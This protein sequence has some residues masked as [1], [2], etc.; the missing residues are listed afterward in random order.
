MNRLNSCTPL[1]TGSSDLISNV[2]FDGSSYFC[3]VEYK[4]EIIKLDNC[5]NVQHKYCTCREYERICYDW[6]EC[7]FWASSRTCSSKIFKLDRNMNEIDHISIGCGCG[8]ITGISYN[9][10]KDTLM[11]SSICIVAEIDKKC[12]TNSILYS[13]KCGW[14]VDVLSLSPGTLLTVL[15][16]GTYYIEV[17]DACGK[18]QKCY[19]ISNEH[20][21][22][23]L[24]FN[25]C[26][27]KSRCA[28]IEVYCIKKN[29]YPNICKLKLSFTELGFFPH[30][31]NY[32]LCDDCCCAE[33]SCRQQDACADIMESIALV[34]AALSHI[35][36]AEGEKLQKVLT[37]TNDVEEILR[38]NRE[39]NK[40]IVNTT[41]LEHVLHAKL[42]A[43]TDCNLCGE[44]CHE[45]CSC[46]K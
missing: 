23:N 7:C 10:R 13:G 37:E 46:E 1:I 26:A 41:H 34:E 45:E 15:R 44:P 4:Y 17:L 6:G 19:C 22:K 25:P 40:T 35:L 30:C 20:T 31:C 39:V 3:T 32:L 27:T 29:C 33:D 9:C 43:L 12:G 18:I 14:I 11:V 2:T 42:E 38:V 36:N 21:L 24:I 8:T 5:F 16:D 28:E